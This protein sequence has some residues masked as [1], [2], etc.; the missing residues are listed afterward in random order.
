MRRWKKQYLD[1]LN[2]NTPQNNQA[3]TTEQ[4]NNRTTE[5]TKLREVHWRAKRDNEILK[6][7]SSD[8]QTTEL[9]T[10]FNI[11]L[12]THHYQINKQ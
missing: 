10:L 2:G 3:L 5:N 6:K 11:A 7:A 8:Y 9:C 4:Q 1:E 12:S